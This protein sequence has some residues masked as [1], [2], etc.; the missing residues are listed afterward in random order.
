[1]TVVFPVNCAASSVL[2]LPEYTARWGYGHKG[3]VRVTVPAESLL[4][5]TRSGALPFSTQSAIAVGQST[6][7]GPRAPPLTLLV[8]LHCGEPRQ[9]RI[10][11]AMPDDELAAA[12]LECIEIRIGRV[13]IATCPRRVLF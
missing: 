9:S 4:A 3:R 5:I 6:V 12:G 2:P 8:V 1:P 11:P 7:S 13:E 10:G